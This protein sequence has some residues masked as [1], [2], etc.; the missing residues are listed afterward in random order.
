ME[1]PRKSYAAFISTLDDMVGQALAEL[2]HL[3]L[4]D[5]T[6]V[7][8][9]ADHGHSTEVRTFSGGG[10][11]GPYRGA[12]FSLFEGGLRV[13][14]IVRLPSRFPSGITRNQ[15]ATAVDWLP[16][17]AEVTGATLPKNRDGTSL[18]PIIQSDHA[19]D[20]HQIFHWQTG[21][22]NNP[23]WAVRS[24]PWKLIGNPQDTSNKG[25]ITEQDKLFLCNLD[26]DVTEMTN[27]A[28]Q[29]PD[30]VNKLST[31]HQEWIQSL[32]PQAP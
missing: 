1:E 23:Q 5:N 21:T 9:M 11:A 4:S 15:L 19:P 16:T 2:E 18:V 22:R 26:A 27:L 13:P 32:R 6:L 17:I 8:F 28:N 14:T 7:I 31:L 24:G 25:P 30:V 12:K 10:N 3:G 20:A 29:H